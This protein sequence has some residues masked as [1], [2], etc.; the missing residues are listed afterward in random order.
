MHLSNKS[1][2]LPRKWGPKT[3][4][5]MPPP[6]PPTKIGKI[7]RKPS[8]ARSLSFQKDRSC[9]SQS[10]EFK[11]PPSV[12]PPR[13]PNH[14]FARLS[15]AGS[16]FNVNR[17]DKWKSN[18]LVDLNQNIKSASCSKEDLLFRC[19][20]NDRLQSSASGTQKWAGHHQPLASRRQNSGL[21]HTA[22]IQNKNLRSSGSWKNLLLDGSVDRRRSLFILKTELIIKVF[23]FFVSVHFMF[24]FIS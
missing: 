9:L 3:T 21:N 16:F 19:S 15:R 10:G 1:S 23:S 4:T 5:D 11:V 8:L 6:L 14:P 12:L 7:F 18:S 20:S 2:T 13:R 22:G 24:S 17:A